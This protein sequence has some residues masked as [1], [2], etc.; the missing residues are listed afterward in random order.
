MRYKIVDIFIKVL[1]TNDIDDKWYECELRGRR[2]LVPKNYLQ[3]TNQFH[4]IQYGEARVSALGK[5]KGYFIF[6]KGKHDFRK[7]NKTQLSFER[8][9]EIQLI[10]AIDQNWYEA[11]IGAHKGYVPKNHLLIIKEPITNQDDRIGQDLISPA[12]SRSSSRANSRPA[13]TAISESDARASPV[14]SN[15][16]Q[17]T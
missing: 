9:E 17:G 3:F 11:R 1:I 4:V 10:R 12:N 13:S 16:S 2:G 7:K 14:K 8:D 15:A 6:F 5:W